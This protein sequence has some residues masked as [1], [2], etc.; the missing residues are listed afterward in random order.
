[1]V[2]ATAAGIDAVGPQRRQPTASIA[3]PPAPLKRRTKRKLSATK[4]T[5]AGIDTIDELITEFKTNDI[6][7]FTNYLLRQTPTPFG[8]A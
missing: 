2:A 4:H 8:R 7:T 6:Q 1:V 3:V 5:I